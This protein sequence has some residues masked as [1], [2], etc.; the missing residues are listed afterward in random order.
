MS[1]D[2]IWNCVTANEFQSWTNYEN[3][4]NEYLSIGAI[5]HSV[6]SNSQY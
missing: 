3:N 4:G 2:D 1:F 6:F 5:I